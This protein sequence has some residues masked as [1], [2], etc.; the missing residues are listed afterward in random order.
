MWKSCLSTTRQATWRPY[1]DWTDSRLSTT[2][3]VVVAVAVDLR[4]QSNLS[5]HNRSL[6]THGGRRILPT[7][8]T[9]RSGLSCCRPLFPVPSNCR[10]CHVIY[11]SNNHSRILCCSCSVAIW[12]SSWGK[13]CLNGNLLFLSDWA[14]LVY[15][16]LQLFYRFLFVFEQDFHLV[17]FLTQYKILV[18]QLI[19]LVFDFSLGLD[20]LQPTELKVFQPSTWF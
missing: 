2:V 4:P 7:L 1:P 19:R 11:C 12:I 20:Q 13:K 6:R 15:L 3:V 17:V 5:E 18:E 10:A 16:L 14:Y 8:W 9:L